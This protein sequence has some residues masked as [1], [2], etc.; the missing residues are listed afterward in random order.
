M[1]NGVDEEVE[2]LVRNSKSPG[3]GIDHGSAVDP[4]PFRTIV[5][6][7][8]VFE[9]RDGREPG[10]GTAICTLDAQAIKLGHALL[11][12]N[13]RSEIIVPRRRH[14]GASDFDHESLTQ[15]NEGLPIPSFGCGVIIAKPLCMSPPTVSSNA[16]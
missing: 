9:H 3:P 16:L 15:K 14:A 7:T 6:S 4:D 2:L 11:K 10:I 8:E 5:G 1:V 12:P 13:R